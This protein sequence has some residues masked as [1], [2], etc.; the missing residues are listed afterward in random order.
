MN[1]P[2]TITAMLN[3]YAVD[4]AHARHVAD[5]AL[6][7]FDQSKPIHKLS[8]KAR[9]LL[10]TGA[11]LHNV[12]LNINQPLHHI[13]GRDIVLDDPL[14]DL[15]EDERAMIACL[16]MFH[17]KKVQA[18]LEPA[19]LR[20]RKKDQQM[21]LRL[22]AL[23]R[24]ADGLDYSESQSTTI[25]SLEIDKKSVALHLAGPHTDE[26]LPR[27]RKKADLWHTVLDYR[28]NIMQVDDAA[29][30]DISDTPNGANGANVTTG[31][32]VPATG[33]TTRLEPEAETERLADAG[34]RLL[35]SHFAEPEAVPAEQ[36]EQP[37]QPTSDS[38]S[39]KVM[40]DSRAPLAATDRLADAGRRLLRSYFCR[41]LL[42]EKGVR[43]NIDPEAVHDMRVATRRLR[44]ILQIISEVAPA[45]DVRYFRKELRRLANTLSGMRDAD[46]FLNAVA[47][48]AK[49]LPPD[50]LSNL[51]TLSSALRNDREAGF[52]AAIDYLNSER[53]EDFKRDFAAFMT[54]DASG[55]DT[56][57]RLRDRA[58][59]II[60]Q[61]YEALRMYELQIDLSRDLEPQIEELH[62]LRIAGK[63]MRYVLEMFADATGSQTD[64]A[65]K[66]LKDMQEHLGTLQDI[67]VA[68]DYLAQ[69]EQRTG[70]LHP[71]VVAYLEHRHSEKHA[72]LAAFPASWE[73]M[74]SETYRRD[75]A[76]LLVAL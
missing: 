65:L 59:S 74:R 73:R 8:G 38:G 15:N 21:V 13:V 48:Y 63:R 49:H 44:A 37:E 42:E 52:A 58:G 23:L 16:V 29:S 32:A 60:W 33:K 66:P 27:A 4:Q 18:H 7:L 31:S 72:L 5:L 61:H 46:V 19:F 67:A 28:M 24:I 47:T 69:L 68:D 12:G 3:Q 40:P 51:D 56:E 20:L 64:K 53:Y 11:L 50:T 71:D 55:W 10:E 43:Q 62:N 1:T 34:R 75:M 41:L 36:P 45:N 14:L 57:T 35:H 2:A 25:A 22:A 54:D 17:R 76:R 26:D 9:R 30:G 6:H 39:S 70:N